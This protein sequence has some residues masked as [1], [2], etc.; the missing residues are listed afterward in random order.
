VAIQVVGGRRM[1]ALTHWA[2]DAE[3]GVKARSTAN[4]FPT[5]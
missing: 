1:R 2:V 3:A 5:R 4:Y